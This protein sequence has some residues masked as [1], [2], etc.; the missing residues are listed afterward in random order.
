MDFKDSLP[1]AVQKSVPQIEVTDIDS[2]KARAK[3]PK[4]CFHGSEAGKYGKKWPSLSFKSPNESETQEG[5][6][7]CYANG[8]RTGISKAQGCL[9]FNPGHTS[10]VAQTAVNQFSFSVGLAFGE[11]E[12]QKYVGS[13]TLAAKYSG[14]GQKDTSSHF[15][16]KKGQYGELFHLL[17]ARLFQ[18]GISI[19][20][21]DQTRGEIGDIFQ[22]FD[23]YGIKS[24]P[25]PPGTGDS[26]DEATA[27]LVEAFKKNAKNQESLFGATRATLERL[28][29]SSFKSMVP[30]SP[31]YYCGVSYLGKYWI[32]RFFT[33]TEQGVQKPEKQK[34]KLPNATEVTRMALIYIRKQAPTGKLGRSMTDENI[35]VCLNAIARANSVA[36]NDGKE[37]AYFSHVL[38]FGDF[39]TSEEVERLQELWGLF[40]KSYGQ[41]K[42]RKDQCLYITK[43]W[44]S[45]SNSQDMAK[46]WAE[47]QAQGTNNPPETEPPTSITEGA[48][49][50][51]KNMAMFLALQARYQEKICAIGFRSGYLDLAGLIGIPTFFVNEAWKTDPDFD[52]KKL[53][54][55]PAE[56]TSRL[57]V[58]SNNINTFICIDFLRT[59]KAEGGKDPLWDL[60]TD[61]GVGDRL[62]A[63]LYV[64]M[65][66]KDGDQGPLW[67]QRVAL[68]EEKVA[69]GGR[70]TLQKLVD[71]FIGSKRR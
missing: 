14:M 11:N 1:E 59:N 51:I 29:I 27:V 42:L 45:T 57:V 56:N 62:A 4:L 12:Y 38:F 20:N 34:W 63:A 25:K 10:K 37:S 13:P 50:Q 15:K 60:R 21:E 69:P 71:G 7:I 49:L 32:N 47:Y 3:T 26:K 24:V 44:M 5:C 68:L 43:P 2:W 61:K 6:I 30:G 35:I 67:K 18:P 41:T 55:L 53:I 22:A 70:G 23:Y 40:S 9:L 8:F 46:F 28:D 19:T 31:Q 39:E 54:Y 64:F 48:P 65:L 66:F 36:R 17:F 16:V 58:A 52:L 33:L